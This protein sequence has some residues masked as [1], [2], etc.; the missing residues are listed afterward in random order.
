LKNSEVSLI[1]A[2]QNAR[3]A[4]ADLRE[5]LGWEPNRPL[6]ELVPV[7]KPT[8]PAK[9]DPLTAYE[10]KAIAERPDLKSTSESIRAFNYS[11]RQAEYNSRVSYQLHGSYVRNFQEESSSDRSIS[12]FASIPL[13]DAGR[14]R[15][16]VRE[17]KASRDAAQARFEQTE[18]RVRSDVESA[19]LS[20]SLNIQ[21]LTAASLAL[22]AAQLNYEAATEGRKEGAG[23]L[24]D[25]I[26]AQLALVQA[27]TNNVNA[28]Y[29]FYIANAQLQ[30]VSGAPMAGELP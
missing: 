28:V 1:Q 14:S 6:P 19:Y 23:S 15:S 30:F 27:E 12:F 17:T 10:E 8:P 7:P 5:T 11:I 24:T 18:R 2:Q 9:I 4:E 13:F 3:V 26:N 29:N 22:E 20:Y 25:V 21:A 16:I